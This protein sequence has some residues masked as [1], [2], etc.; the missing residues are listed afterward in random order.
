M[1]AALCG[2]IFIGAGTLP[3]QRQE[4]FPTL[5]KNSLNFYAVIAAVNHSLLARASAQVARS[6]SFRKTP[7]L[8]L[9]HPGFS[10]GSTL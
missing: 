7:A 9:N 2:R 10:G 3:A 1:L 6:S 8:L 5:Q 4:V